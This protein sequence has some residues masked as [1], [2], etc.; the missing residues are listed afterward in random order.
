M[1]EILD[2]SSHFSSWD[3]NWAENPLPVGTERETSC[4]SRGE[5]I[6]RAVFTRV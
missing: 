4:M 6:F 2:A 5:P 3:G 1:V